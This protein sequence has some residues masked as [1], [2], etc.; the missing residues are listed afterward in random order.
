MFVNLYNVLYNV[1]R[2]AGFTA[3]PK[4]FLSLFSLWAAVVE[5]TSK[6]LIKMVIVM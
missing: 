2:K 1:V 5:V 3:G 4:I 6:I